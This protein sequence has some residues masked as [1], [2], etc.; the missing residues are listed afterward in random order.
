VKLLAAHS[1]ASFVA[2]DL[3]ALG[4]EDLREAPLAERRERL[5]Q[6]LANA[7]PPV[8]ISPATRDRALAEDWF[9][10]LRGR[11]PRRRHGQASG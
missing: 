5:E 6:A 7:A 4:D 10:A 11:R 2:W 3:L 9:S 8:H 1:P